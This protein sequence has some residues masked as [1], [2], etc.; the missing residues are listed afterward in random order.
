MSW[1]LKE[2]RNLAV[3]RYGAETI[4]EAQSGEEKALE[5]YRGGGGNWN[6]TQEIVLQENRLHKESRKE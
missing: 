6:A 5:G 4:K 1:S 2:E 3:L